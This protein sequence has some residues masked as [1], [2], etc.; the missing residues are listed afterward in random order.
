MV[1]I[2][3][4]WA[5]VGAHEETL[6]AGEGSDRRELE[7]ARKKIVELQL[8]VAEL[9]EQSTLAAGQE[10][11]SPGTERGTER[12]GTQDEG[13]A[14]RVTV[15]Q[16]AVS[17][18]SGHPQKANTAD[19]STDTAHDSDQ[20]V[21][22]DGNEMD[23]D[24]AGS[25]AD[26]DTDAEQLFK[27][28][29]DGADTLSL[30]GLRKVVEAASLA[31]PEKELQA[32][33][34]ELDSTGKGAITRD[35]FVNGWGTRPSVGNLEAI[36]SLLGCPS[37]R[38]LEILAAGLLE[39]VSKRL[40][41]SRG[42]AQ[43]G[44]GRIQ[45][46]LGALTPEDLK[47]T[48]REAEDEVVTGFGQELKDLQPGEEKALLAAGFNAKFS[49][50]FKEAVLKDASAYSGGVEALLGLPGKDVAAGIEMEFCHSEDSKSEFKTSNYNGTITTPAE[51]YKFVVDPEM[52]KEYS[53]QRKG[54]PLDVF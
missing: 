7:A 25:V 29:A 47:E 18:A 5:G 22:D 9:Q 31:L 15:R 52:G 32:L 35:D 43:Q 36:V 54:T 53:G 40:N 4:F 12:G 6:R 19:I 23:H 37:V 2:S 14:A 10:G 41:A 44:S 38:I 42:V 17:E 3:G 39:R 48:W 46:I 49:P 28:A 21:K 30:E 16:A 24:S 34:A 1:A 33:F 20:P 51:E 8:Q 45:T 27:E 11:G 26:V 13:D 50:S